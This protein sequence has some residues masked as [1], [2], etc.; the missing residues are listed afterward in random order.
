MSGYSTY[1]RW[2]RIEAQAKILGFRLGNPKSGNWGGVGD[3]D[4]VALYPDGT[5]LPVFSRDSEIYAGSFSQ[6]ET[7]MNG[8]TRAR[9][10]DYILRLS[11]NEKRKKAEAKEVERQRLAKEREEKKKMFAIL[12]DKEEKDVERIM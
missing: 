5:A 12:A 2:Q 8:W 9:Q 3:H 4:M 6:I 1:T 10:Y 7:F 11:N